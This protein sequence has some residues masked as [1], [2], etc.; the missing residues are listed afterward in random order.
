MDPNEPVVLELRGPFTEKPESHTIV[1]KLPH[2]HQ[3]D[4]EAV[5]H[6]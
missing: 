6:R 3:A 2:S 1:L 4:T 5:F